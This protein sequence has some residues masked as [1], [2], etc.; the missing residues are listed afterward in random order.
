MVS[1]GRAKEAA[2]IFEKLLD[3]AAK[4]PKFIGGS[5]VDAP[6]RVFLVRVKKARALRLAQDYAAAQSL[7]DELANERKNDL[8]VLL[9]RGQLAE[10]RA[11]ADSTL[12]NTSLNYWTWLAGRLE[13]ASRKGP[14]YF[15]SYYHVALA[16]FKTGD[17]TKAV[18]TLKGIMILSPSV[19]SP[20]MKAKYQGLL[21]QM[22]S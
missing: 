3:T 19:G 17:K 10:D 11:Q 14:P 1:I 15:E 8:P 16:R 21:K 12:W 2:V 7:I 18:Q 20:E 6:D 22:G 4:D 13:R 5:P 9:E